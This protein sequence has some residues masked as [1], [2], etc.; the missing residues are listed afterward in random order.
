M[1]SKNRIQLRSEWERL[2]ADRLRNDQRKALEE[3]EKKPEIYLCEKT[4]KINKRRAAARFV[5]RGA[6]SRYLT[7]PNHKIDNAASHSK[8]HAESELRRETPGAQLTVNPAHVFL[9]P[10]NSI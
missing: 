2:E 1:P 6:V 3:D 10:T 5:E 8:R 7:D 9:V 4:P